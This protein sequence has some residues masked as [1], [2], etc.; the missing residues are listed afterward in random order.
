MTFLIVTSRYYQD[1]AKDL[2][3]GAQAAL[4]KAAESYRTL[5][6][7]GAFELPGAISAVLEDNDHHNPFSGFIALGCVIRGKTDHY[8]YVCQQASRGLAD[9]SHR[10]ALGFGL[11]TCDH[12]QDAKERADPNGR[13]DV[14]GTAARACL[15]M[16]RWRTRARDFARDDG[17][18]FDAC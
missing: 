3:A 10:T 18:L 11:L 12:Q 16:H 4:R 15:A 14:G 2:E 1:I 5:V 8:E 9:L 6:V 7:P 17:D 13:H